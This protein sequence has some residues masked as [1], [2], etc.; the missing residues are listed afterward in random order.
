MFK[1]DLAAGNNA[2]NIFR[3]FAGQISD[4]NIL[5]PIRTSNELV[6][7]KDILSIGIT[8]KGHRLVTTEVKAI[9]NNHFITRD[10][11]N[12][13]ESGTLEFEL[14]SN[15]WDENGNLKPR[16]NWTIG[17]LTAMLNPKA[18][19]EFIADENSSI[20]VEA[21]DQ[22]AFMLCDDGHGKKPYA[23]VLFP[24][25]TKLKNRLIK[26]AAT[27]EAPFDLEHLVSP[28]HRLGFWGDKR[29][30][31][32]FNTWYVPLNELVDLAMITIFSDVPIRIDQ[33]SK[34]CPIYIQNAR[35]DYLIAHASN[36][37]DRKEEYENAQAAGRSYKRD[38]G[39][40]EDAPVPHMTYFDSNKLPPTVQ[41]LD[42]LSD[43]FKD[44]EGQE[45]LII[46]PGV[47]SE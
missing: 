11:D 42:N 45:C 2:E 23:C 4:V 39:L 40:P 32:P 7:G 27:Q 24:N 28:M 36:C 38:L 6:E 25:F 33:Q 14:W 12:L 10:N 22:L 15:A 47:R 29:R 9:L 20:T 34:K 41:R 17:W 1:S 16:R 35:K 8:K 46:Q 21:P 31:V 19:N 13:A 18:Y 43:W 44:Y 30:N 5:S 3:H 26:I 37:F